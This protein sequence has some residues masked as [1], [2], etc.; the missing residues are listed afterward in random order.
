A[1]EPTLV[2]E[3]LAELAH[4]LG[5]AAITDPVTAAVA[6]LLGVLRE[7][8]RWLLI[9]DNA[10]DPVALVPYLPGGGQVVITSRNPSWQE[11]ATLVGVDVFKRGESV[12]FLRR[13]V[14]Q[15]TDGDAGRIAEALGDLPLAL[16]QAAGYLTD[17]P[18]GVQDYLTLLAERTAELL[19]QGTPVTYP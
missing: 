10:E 18:T 6:R 15:L 7:R 13:R 2:G 14:P 4:A 19:A 3:R 12:A 1:Q 9:F 17:A 11:L 5:L 8:A 16:T